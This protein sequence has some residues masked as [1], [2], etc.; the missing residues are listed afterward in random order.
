LFRRF[1]DPYLPLFR[2][3]MEKLINFFLEYNPA[4]SVLVN[5]FPISRQRRC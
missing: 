1:A 4:Y 2:G 5:Q 3:E